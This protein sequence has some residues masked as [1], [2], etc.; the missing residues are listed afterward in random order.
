M[1]LKKILTVIVGMGVVLLF[2]LLAGSLMNEES[3]QDEVTGDTV[4]VP[5]NSVDIA[6]LNHLATTNFA[7]F[8]N[9][10]AGKAEWTAFTIK[11]RQIPA[12]TGLKALDVRIP[13]EMESAL[14]ISNWGIYSCAGNSATPKFVLRLNFALTETGELMTYNQKLQALR[15]WESTMLD[16]T[17][18]ILYPS[19][20]YE[21]TNISNNEFSDVS[22]PHLINLRQTSVHSNNL[23]VGDLSYVVVADMLFVGSDTVC[24]IEKALGVIGF[25]GTKS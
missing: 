3:S 16:D 6:E 8:M 24:L 19:E 9:I 18:N 10:N 15:R 5:Q 14:D 7:E 13:A 11:G 25:D 22:N 4:L 17:K 21:L 12:T 2:V 20:F 1:K 23:A